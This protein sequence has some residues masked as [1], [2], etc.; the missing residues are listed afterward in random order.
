MKTIRTWGSGR[1][2]G[3]MLQCGSNIVE[4][5]ADGKVSDKTGALNHIALATDDVA[6]CVAAVESAGY[7][8]KLEPVDVTIQSEPPY[9]VSVAFCV[10]PVGEEIEFFKE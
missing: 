7:R 2:A 5:C 9:S 6:A 4:I 8:I 1:D 3:I 10:G